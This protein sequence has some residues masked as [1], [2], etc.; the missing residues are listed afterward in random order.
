MNAAKLVTVRG[1]ISFMDKQMISQWA[2][3]AEAA[4]VVARMLEY[5][6]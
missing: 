1:E 2:V 4:A 5:I 6:K 3:A